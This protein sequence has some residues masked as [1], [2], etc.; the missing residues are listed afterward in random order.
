MSRQIQAGWPSCIAS[1]SSRLVSWAEQIRHRELMTVTT[2]PGEPTTPLP[3]PTT[4]RTPDA[5]TARTA[6]KH[7]KLMLLLGDDE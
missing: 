5:L 4:V 3:R 6:E 1:G 2:T 7:S